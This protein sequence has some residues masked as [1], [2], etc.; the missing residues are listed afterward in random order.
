MVAYVI[1][2]EWGNESS[3]LIRDV[4]N[5][6]EFDDKWSDLSDQ[7]R[8]FFGYDSPCWL[9]ASDADPIPS[10]VTEMTFDEYVKLVEQQEEFQ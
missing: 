2:P 3:V 9:S 10:T 6:S 7:H 5:D 4:G 8:R 1:H